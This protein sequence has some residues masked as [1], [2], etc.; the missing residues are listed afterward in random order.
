MT[1]KAKKNLVSK[2]GMIEWCEQKVEQK[3]LSLRSADSWFSGGVVM[4][5]G[6]LSNTG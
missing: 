5:V 3:I 2:R 6:S 4:K 1:N